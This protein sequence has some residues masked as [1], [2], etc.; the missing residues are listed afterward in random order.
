MARQLH[1]AGEK[2][3]MVA[4]L[5]SAPANAGYES[6]TWWRPGFAFRFIRNLS[7]WLSDFATIDPH[8]RRRFVARKWRTIGRK[9]ARK[10][11][12]T[13]KPSVDIEEVIDPEKFPESELKL[14]RTHLNA[15]QA[16]RQ[17]PY[18]GTVTLFRTRGQPV[19]SSLADD[20]CWGKLA[21]RV[22]VREIPG[23]HEQIFMEPHVKTLASSVSQLLNH[24]PA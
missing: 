5:D 4:L 9:I 12:P 7:Y 18:A 10:F 11:R 15:L 2:V 21:A 14:W 19:L 24:D 17:Q 1:A 23:S 13:N 8:D 20:F 16:H 6:V 22:V 3:A